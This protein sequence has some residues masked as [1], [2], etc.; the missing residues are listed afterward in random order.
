MIKSTYA[1]R[2]FFLMYEELPKIA[3]SDRFRKSPQKNSFL[4]ILSICFFLVQ[5]RSHTIP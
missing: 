2:L 5:K 4:G 1:N 3:Y